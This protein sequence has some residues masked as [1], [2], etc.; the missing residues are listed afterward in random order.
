MK[1]FLAKHDV[2]GSPNVPTRSSKRT[3]L[4]RIFHAVGD[5]DKWEINFLG[6][7]C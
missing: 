6:A 7:M 4:W 1:T 3:V 5:A 2:M